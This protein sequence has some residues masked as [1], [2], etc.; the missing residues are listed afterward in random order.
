MT[1]MKS[2]QLVY[3]RNII[4]QIIILLISGSTIMG[5]CRSN[6][7]AEER[8]LKHFHLDK[9]ENVDIERIRSELFLQLPKG[10]PAS[11]VYKFLDEAEIGKDKLSS[12]HKLKDGNIVCRIEFDPDSPGVLKES[13]GVFFTMDNE[14]GLQDIDIKRWTT[15]L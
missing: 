9:F 4:F 15:G 8:L 6:N 10:S 11:D 13:F 7:T 1:M 12:Y 5:G 2:I 14:E 3:E